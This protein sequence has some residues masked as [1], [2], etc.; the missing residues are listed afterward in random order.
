M[1]LLL[2]FTTNTSLKEWNRGGIFDREILIYKELAKRGI[3]VTFLTYGN[4]TDLEFSNKLEKINVHPINT[5]RGLNKRSFLNIVLYPF[6]HFKFFKRFDLIKTNQMDGSWITWFLKVLFRKK[7][8]IRCGFAEYKTKLTYF[9]NKSKTLNSFFE[10]FFAFV[11]EWISYRIA[12]YII[13]TNHYEKDFI[14][15][16]FKIKPEKIGVLPNYIDI[17]LFRPIHTKKKDKTILYV[18]NLN[19]HKNLD[20]LI[21]SFTYLND[22]KLD[23]IGWGEL[24]AYLNKKIK[25][26]KLDSKIRFLGVIPNSKL[27]DI[28]NQYNIFILPSFTEGNPK[29]LLE[30]MSCGLACIGSNI[31][32]INQIIKH[33]VNGFLCNLDSKSIANAI[34]EVYQDPVLREKIGKNGRQYI[35]KNCS[36]DTIVE[37]EWKIYKSILTLD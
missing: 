20:N 5:K 22:F 36:L 28:I 34:K 27:P 18:G 19:H 17:N 37:K 3:D 25:K 14:I 8:I 4:K 21:E 13:M 26:L 9:K 16:N 10:K 31:R 35:V 30:A 11:I 6:F 1:N 33:R 29:T 7:L 32:G 24:K 2:T 15:N 23:I 12:D